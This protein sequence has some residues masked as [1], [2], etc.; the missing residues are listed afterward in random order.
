MSRME[1]VKEALAKTLSEVESN[2]KTIHDEG[3]TA[4]REMIGFRNGLALAD[5]HINLRSGKATMIDLSA[6]RIVR[7]EK[8]ERAYEIAEAD[9]QE[10][11]YLIDQVLTAARAVCW[12]EAEGR[13]PVVRELG[14]KIIGLDQFVTARLHEAGQGE[15]AGTPDAV[16]ISQEGSSPSPATPSAAEFN[17][18]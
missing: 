13:E 15:V 17:G 12:T 9:E 14:K 2:I 7:T 11:E 18:A 1:R 5:H 4:P 8:M 3:G 16:A 10:Y 6:Q